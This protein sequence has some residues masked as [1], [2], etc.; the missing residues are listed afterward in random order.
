MRLLTI[1]VGVR[2]AKIAELLAKKGTRVN[3]VP[4]FKSFAVLND[5]RAIRS[6]SLPES[7]KF[8]VLNDVSG[9]V[10]AATATYEITEGSLVITSL[11]DDFGFSASLEICERLK[12]VTEDYVLSIAIL[13]QFEMA[14]IVE[15][16]E[17]IREL[18]KKSDVMF[19]FRGTPETE[20]YVLKTFNL[21]ALAGE[22]DLKKRVAGEVVI[23]TSDVFNALRGDG[24]SVV[25]YAERTVPLMSFLKSRSELKAT[26]TKRM[27]E[28]VDEAM[29]NVSVD[30]EISDASSALLLYAANPKEVTMEGIFAAISK[31]EQLND[32][33]VVRYG[34]YPLL[35]S[36]KVSLVLLFSGIRKLKVS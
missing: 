30:S 2:G 26:R 9:V 21:I 3:R 8:Y 25:G 6:V 20:Q 11:E 7:R 1:G 35:R 34:D 28:M 22:I 27:L 33:I 4:L 31:I 17:R 18:R 29:K 32:R 15:L 13:P 10:A 12:D 36:R 24:F 14:K 5:E 16:R 19:L 23:D